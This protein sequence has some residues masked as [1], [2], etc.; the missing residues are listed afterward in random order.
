MNTARRINKIRS[1]GLR[2]NPHRTLFRCS[3]FVLGP[4]F[5]PGLDDWK[6]IAIGTGLRLTAHPELNVTRVARRGKVL[7]ALGFLLD[8]H[9]PTAGDREILERLMGRFESLGQLL[10]ATSSLGGRW[11]IIAVNGSERYLF[12]DAFGLRQVF[13]TVPNTAGALYVSSEPSAGAALLGLSIDD[14]ARAYMD[15]LTFR[16]SPEYK[17]PAAGSPFQGSRRLLPNHFLDLGNGEC[18][19]FWPEGG[20]SHISL[21]EGAGRVAGL[22]TGLLHAAANRFDLAVTVT[23]GIDSRVVLAACMDIREKVSFVTLRQWHMG[24]DSPDIVVPEN[25]LNRLGLRHQVIRSSVNTTPDFAQIFKSNAF[26]AHEHYGPDAE[27]ILKRFQRRMVAVTGS[28]GEVGRCPFR[29]NLRFFDSKRLSPRYLC[30]IEI[31]AQSEFA[32]KHFREW[33]GGLPHGH[34]I[35]R[36]DIFEWEQGCGSWLATTQLQFDIA[37]KDIVT[38]FN[39]REIAVTMLSVPVRY[40]KGP[41]YPLFQ[42]LVAK[43]WPEVLDAPINPHRRRSLI[44]QRWYEAQ[45]IARHLLHHLRNR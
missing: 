39:C 38:P 42:R 29:S 32:M 16:T 44:G 41:D 20:V 31:G 28:G 6:H 43:M 35:N 10:Q 37:W 9:A 19:R 4:E 7:A 45:L 1:I 33:L 14:D 17:W 40:R 30:R 21:D 13:Y 22:L 5:A 27:A 15:S 24:D 3:Q 26:E 11:A 23:S 18:R 36:L 2:D 25:L 34:N 12:A 8:P